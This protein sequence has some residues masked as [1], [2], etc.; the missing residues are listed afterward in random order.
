MFIWT[1]KQPN[2]KKFPHQD[3]LIFLWGISEN[4]HFNTQTTKCLKVPTSRHPN[5][6]WGISKNVNCKQIIDSFHLNVTA[7]PSCLR[8]SCIFSIGKYMLTML[9]SLLKNRTPK[10]FKIFSEFGHPILR[11]CSSHM[12]LNDVLNLC[13]Y[14]FVCVCMCVCVCVCVWNKVIILIY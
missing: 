9:W 7:I 10:N 6:S 3:T 12:F 2:A 11:P 1:P 4:V 5:F 14:V 13:M 8:L